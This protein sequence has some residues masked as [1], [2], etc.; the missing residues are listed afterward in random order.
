MLG[1]IKFR[2]ENPNKPNIAYLNIILEKKLQVCDKYVWK[3]DILCVDETKLDAF[4]PNA[5]F[6]IEGYQFSPFCRDR[7]KHGGGKMVFVRN[8]IIAKGLESLEG[9]ESDAICIEVTIS[10]KKW[11]ITFADRPPQNEKK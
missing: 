11:C 4:Y 6:H 9:K 3:V 1:L 2:K 10:K 5:Q 7:N 8:S